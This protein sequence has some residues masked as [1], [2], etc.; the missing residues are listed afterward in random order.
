MFEALLKGITLGL[1]LSI[2][3]GPVL[4]SIIKQSLNSG[5]RGGISFVLGVSASDIALVLVSNVFTSFFEYMVAHKQFIGIG[6]SLFL[7]TMGVYFIFFKKVKVDD[8]GVQ[9][10]PLRKR[11]YVKTFLSGFFMNLLN[12]AVFIFWL[13]TSTTLITLS[14]EYRIIAFVTCLAFVLATDLLKVF[15]AQKIRRK[16]TPHNIQILSRI[17]G[18]ILLSF[19]LI[20]IW[21]LIFYTK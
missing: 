7:V 9:V 15:M 2:S 19:G 1:L 10:L 18:L 3:V 20:L 17:N 6:G 5:H 21:G 8:S 12:P 13:T 16:L 14:I 4:F 11:D